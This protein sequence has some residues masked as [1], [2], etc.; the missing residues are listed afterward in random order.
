MLQTWRLVEIRQLGNCEA[1]MP[2]RVILAAKS[3]DIAIAR[4]RYGLRSMPSSASLM[5]LSES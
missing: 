1:N 2:G 5:L 3:R 4:D